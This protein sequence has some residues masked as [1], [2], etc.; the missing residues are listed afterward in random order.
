MSQI[1]LLD[2]GPLSLITHPRASAESN[3]C[4]QW[5]RDQLK[6]GLGILVPGISDYELRREMLLNRATNGIAKLDALRKTVGFVP[7]TSEVMDQA[8]AFWA[9]A[10]K[11]GKPTASDPALDGDMILS[12][13]AQFVTNHGHEVIVATTN[14]KHLNL[15]CDARLWTSIN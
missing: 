1:V 4:N 8:A 10:R 14:I 15:F 9:E 13:Q 5:M 7:I 3:Q 12:A 2:T 11:M 6:N